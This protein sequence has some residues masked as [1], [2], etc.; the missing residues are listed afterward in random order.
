MVHR[1][2]QNRTAHASGSARSALFPVPHYVA[3]DEN[4]SPS[5]LG[6]PD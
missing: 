5:Y 1:I 6:D 2:Q 3:W 4:H